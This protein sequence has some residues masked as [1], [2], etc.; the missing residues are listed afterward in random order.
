MRENEIRENRRSWR[1]RK[2]F[3][4]SVTGGLIT[5]D[6]GVP[7]NIPNIEIEF[8]SVRVNIRLDTVKLGNKRKSKLKILRVDTYR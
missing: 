8:Q 5:F 6:G 4:M 3:E 2:C 1:S 7:H